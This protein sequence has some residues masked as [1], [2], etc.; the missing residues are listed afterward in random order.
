[1]NTTTTTN[2]N[3][4]KLITDNL[5]KI[6]KPPLNNKEKTY[7]KNSKNTYVELMHGTQTQY[8][9]IIIIIIITILV[10]HFVN[11]IYALAVVLR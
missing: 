3:N 8:I 5:I 11:H 1:M 9:I 6:N 7:N 10:F 2:N 4:N